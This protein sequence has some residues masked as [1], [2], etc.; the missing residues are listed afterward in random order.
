MANAYV[1]LQLSWF[2]L[3]TMSVLGH[4]LFVWFCSKKQD[5]TKWKKERETKKISEKYK[6]KI[7]EIKELRKKKAKLK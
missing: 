5:K 1:S 2:I 4:V 6:M 7:T 3:G